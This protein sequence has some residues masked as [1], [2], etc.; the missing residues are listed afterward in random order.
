[1]L[2]HSVA[3]CLLV[4]VGAGCAQLSAQRPPDRRFEMI[5]PE[6]RKEAAAHS[7]E[8]FRFSVGWLDRV[9]E[10]DDPVGDG[11]LFGLDGVFDIATTVLTPS[12]EFGIAW[13]SSH[14][15]LED[16]S[17]VELW[18]G[19]IGLRGTLYADGWR[20]YARGGGFVRW[21]TDDLDEPF[22]PYAPGL[23]AGVG[24][25]WPYQEGLSFGPSITWYRGLHEDDVVEWLF[26]LSATF[27]L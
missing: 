12:L 16:Q 20:P 4:L 22:D 7:R 13:S 27:R 24:I 26:A 19:A 18:R 10:D 8:S 9:Q 17:S 21:S 2:H 3:T 6:L 23:Y 11:L 5:R 14:A 15:D 1:V 25:D